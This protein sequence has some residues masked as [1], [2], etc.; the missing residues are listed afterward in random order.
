MPQN[1]MNIA[2]P[3]AMKEFVLR[4][5][6]DGGYSTASEYVRE[7]IRADQKRK[8]GDR[9]DALLLEGLDGGRSAPLT[10][11]DWRDIRDQ[12]KSRLKR[13]RK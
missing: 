3:E 11:Q 10:K 4:Q 8:A 7:L 6:A 13:G 1:S 9:L 5:V 2:L 12:V